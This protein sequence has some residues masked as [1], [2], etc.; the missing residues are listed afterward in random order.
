MEASRTEFSSL[1]NQ[2]RHLGNFG[3]IVDNETFEIQGFA[4][5]FD[6]NLSMLCNALEDDL[7]NFER[8]EEEFQLGHK[9]GEKFSERLTFLRGS[10]IS[11]R[12]R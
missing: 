2:D 4:P 12:A 6:Y 7:E 5:L 3:F 10:C 8:Y 1:F 9:L 11:R